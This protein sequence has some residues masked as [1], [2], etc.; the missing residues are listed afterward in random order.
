MFALPPPPPPSAASSTQDRFPS[1]VLL[2]CEGCGVPELW[3][4]LLLTKA[5]ASAAVDSGEPN[6]RDRQGHYFDHEARYLLGPQW[7]AQ[8]WPLPIGGHKLA[9]DGSATY[10]QSPQ[11]RYTSHR[12]ET[13]CSA[14]CSRTRGSAAC[15]RWQ[16]RVLIIAATWTTHFLPTRPSSPQHAQH[17][18]CI[19]HAHHID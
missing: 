17:A 18:H 12:L 7:Y 2:G 5:F 19:H 6:W 1:L 14:L 9:I 15:R 10:L 11:A 8:R 16:R 4:S 3:R 13:P